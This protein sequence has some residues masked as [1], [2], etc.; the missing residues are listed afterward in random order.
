MFSLSD[1]TRLG[2]L[3]VGADGPWRGGYF[4]PTLRSRSRLNVIGLLVEPFEGLLRE[5]AP[6][7]RIP[8]PLLGDGP[9]LVVARLVLPSPVQPR[10]PLRLPLLSVLVAGEFEGPFLG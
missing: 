3:F 9:D 1:L 7:V 10:P 6:R 5:S 4:L 8:L 2:A